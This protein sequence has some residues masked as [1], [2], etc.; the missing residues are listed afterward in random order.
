MKILGLDTSTLMTTCAVMDENTLLGEYSL[1]QDMSHSESLVPMIQEVMESLKL[2][3]EDI[4]LY[5]V[6]IGPGSF[7]GLRIGIA[8]IKAFAHVFDKPV[9]G[10]S[11]LEALVWN[12]PFNEII[13]PMIDAR[14]DRVYTGIYTWE[15][16]NLKTIMAPDVIEINKLLEILN[17]RYEKIVVNGNGSLLYRDLISNTLNERVQFST[18]GNNALRASSICELALQKFKENK[19]DDYFTLSPEYL[20]ESQAQRELKERE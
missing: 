7:T 11:T 13:V 4:D 6:G 20:K 5:G 2:K 9:V 15:K 18:I 1:S 17:N 10:V 14:R 8:T 19:I 3:I 16:D 12:L